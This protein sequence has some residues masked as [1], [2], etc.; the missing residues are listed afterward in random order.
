[1]RSRLPK[2]TAFRLVAVALSLVVAGDLPAQLKGHYIPGFTG[3]Q[4]GSQPPPSIS[5][6]VPTYFYTTNDIR[7]DNGDSFAV[8]PRV[9]VT[10]IGPGVVWSTRASVFGGRL[11]GSAFPIAFIKSRIEG[12]SLDVPAS[13][14]FTDIYLQPIQLGWHGKKA[15]FVVGYGI[16][17]PTGTWELGGRDNSGLGMRS[18]LFQAGTTLHLAQEWSFSTLASYEI[19]SLKEDTDLRVGDILTL[20]GGIGKTLISVRM[21]GTQPVPTSIATVGPIYYA[22]YKVTSDLSPVLTP[23]LEGNRDRVW[24][25][26]VDGT[27]IL[28]TSGWI[29]GLRVA[30][31]FEARNRPQGWAFL[32]TLGHGL[33]SLAKAPAATAGA[34][35]AIS[36]R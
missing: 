13:F 4:N 7:D 27:I 28:P 19:H 2:S 15:D 3:L 20:E 14:D 32:L 16:F 5:V 12:P 1:M 24:G 30:R 31:E 35:G 25:V 11:G 26:G 34:E 10:F 36:A 29:F 8:H 18:N 23:L 21:A 17:L 6:V 9:N 22:Q 33:K